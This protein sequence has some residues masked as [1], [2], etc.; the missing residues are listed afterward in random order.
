MRLPQIKSRLRPNQRERHAS[1]QLIARAKPRIERTRRMLCAGVAIFLLL[2]RTAY[3]QERKPTTLS[4]ITPRP[5]LETVSAGRNKPR[6]ALSDETWVSIGPA[7]VALGNNDVISGQVNALAVHPGNAN[8]V[9]LGAS[10]GGVWRTSDGGVNW[11][12]LTD[13]QLVREIPSSSGGFVSRGTLSIGSLAISPQNSEVIYVGTGDSNIGGPIAGPDLGVFRS[14]NGGSDWIPLGNARN[15]GCG[16]NV[17]MSEARVNKLVVRPGSP[18]VV[19]AATNTGIFKYKEDGTDCWQKLTDGLPSSNVSDLVQDPARNILYAAFSGQGIF[20]TN[21]PAGERW[22]RLTAGLPASGFGRVAL[23]ISLS[24]LQ[25]LYAGFD[26]GGRYGLFKTTSSGEMW[27]ALPP[28]P[29]DGQLNFNNALAVSPNRTDSVYVGQVALWR[30]GDGGAKG[31]LNDYSQNPPVTGNSWSNL[32]CCLT[33]RNPNR[34]GLDLHADIHDIVFAPRGSFAESPSVAE[35]IYVAND[36]GVTKGVMN[37][38]GVITWQPMTRGVAIGQFGTIGLSPSNV[39]EVIGG[40]WHNGNAFTSSGGASWLPIHGGDGFQTT[41]DASRPVTMYINDN[42]LNGG[43]IRRVRADFAHTTPLIGSEVIWSDGSTV[44]YW[45]DPYRAGELVRVQGGKLY[46]THRADTRPVSEV[47]NIAAWELIEPPGKSGQTTIMTF[48]RKRDVDDKPV[49]YLG[50]NTGQVWRGS[51][52]IGWEK[53]CDCGI[54]VRALAIDLN[55][56]NRLAAVFQ[57]ETSPGR[58]K[59]LTRTAGGA[60]MVRNIDDAFNPALQA[61]SLSCVAID[62]LDP[63]TVFVGTDQ[64]IYRGRFESSAW[65]WTRSPGMPNVTVTDIEVH[66]RFIGGVTGVVRAG[67]YGRGI[68]ELQRILPITVGV[69]L[70]VQAVQIG[71]DGALPALNVQLPL[72]TP[73]GTLAQR[74]PFDLVFP[75]GAQV[76]LQ[77]PAEIQAGGRRLRFVEWAVSGQSLQPRPS[78]TLALNDDTAV[79][80]HYELIGSATNTLIVQATRVGGDGAPRTPQASIQIKTPTGIRTEKTPFELSLP[81]NAPNLEITLTAPP[82]IRDGD[83]KLQFTGWLVSGVILEP[84][85]SIPLTLDRNRT[86][87]A[88][89]QRVG[90]P[91][92]QSLCF[93]APQYFALNFSRLPEGVVVI[94]GI[95][96]NIPISASNVAAI[97]LA[98][99]GGASPLQRLN[100]EFLAAQLSLE[101]AGG[102][103]SPSVFTALWSLLSCSGLSFAPATLS[104]GFTLTPNSMLND[105]FEQTRLAIRDNRAADMLVLANLFAQINGNDP[106]GRC[107]K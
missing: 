91:K 87:L 53:V 60:W 51:P 72:T 56:P 89:Y 106:L 59:E 19:F 71:V 103:S 49:Y 41:L 81:K 76:T 25:T 52:E 73:T 83:D 23:A 38:V 21:D 94:G 55:T 22:A 16:Q 70:S 68:F 26:L 1:Q 77:A 44:A 104:N 64:G 78:I 80:A 14:N 24:S 58:I 66:Q 67:T 28:A 96:F 100:R 12:P 86:A 30:A 11:T 63:N 92:C 6:A 57:G 65:G 99:A 35:I 39:R 34:R 62:P 47:N 74:T 107:G 82:T 85:E 18:T 13:L 42:A 88:Y 8:I 45:S 50:T 43:A 29:N 69:S 102:H 101:L 75:M 105:L 9:Y 2:G 4:F 97:R 36:G 3:V 90:S 79:M 7:G 84:G 17:A 27:S 93:R 54:G 61:R 95:N 20:K 33:D 32:S 37:D 40:Y 10:E 31:G 5:A 48:D 15:S 98:L 46:R